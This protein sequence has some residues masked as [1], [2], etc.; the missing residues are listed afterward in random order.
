MTLSYS[1]LLLCVSLATMTLANT[2]LLA[3]P[4]EKAPASTA[5]T[6]AQIKE[7]DVLITAFL[8]NHPDVVMTSLQA[9]AEK[10]QQEEIKKMETAV[11]GQME[12][13]FNDKETPFLGNVAGAQSLVVFFDPYCG[14]CRKFHKE[15]TPVV[16]K[17]KD[18]K[19]LLND[20]PIMGPQSI[21]AVQAMLAAKAQGKYDEFQKALFALEEPAS[22]KKLMKIAKSL[23][24]D[25]KKFKADMKGPAVKKRIEHLMKL[26]KTIGITGTPTLI[27]NQKKV[28]PG[29]LSSEELEKELKGEK[30]EEEKKTSSDKKQ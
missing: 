25:T 14:H 23:G 20:I 3:E 7:L 16:E 27:I 4:A 15:L 13:L 11:Q 10:Q 21:L 22:E 1:R 19:V 9:G 8:V 12:A 18:L 6:P 30:K 24:L 26:T 17:N 28:V 5:F 2:S 29:Y